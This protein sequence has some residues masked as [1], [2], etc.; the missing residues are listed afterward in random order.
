MK[1][2][3]WEGIPKHI[4]MEQEFML[5]F[6][7]LAKI[8]SVKGATLSNVIFAGL[9]PSFE[10]GF[11]SPGWPVAHVA[12]LGLKLAIL[13]LPSMLKMTVCTTSVLCQCPEPK[14]T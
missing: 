11:H 1:L 12:Q 10:I 14:F 8:S 7:P 2:P 4:V 13:L 5:V 3:E 9:F 6:R